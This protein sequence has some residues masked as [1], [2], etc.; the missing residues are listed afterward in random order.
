M[1]T[2]TPKDFSQEELNSLAQQ[3][4]WLL[5]RIVDYANQLGMEA[6]V[7]LQA[8][9]LLVTGRIISGPKYLEKIAEGFRDGLA[10]NEG[11]EEAAE[12]FKKLFL[13]FKQIYAKPEDGSLV[14]PP[15]FI[16]LENARFL[17]PGKTLPADGDGVLWRG[18]ISEITG[19]TFSEFR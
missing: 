15:T 4:D 10:R 13:S 14:A 11:F 3:P 6:G 8:G 9:G 5:Q 7:T 2:D 1:T 17:I 19:F 18:R 16:H 12:Q